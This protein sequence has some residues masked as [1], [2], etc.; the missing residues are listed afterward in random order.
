MEMEA[1]PLPL[2][3]FLKYGFPE[4]LRRPVSDGNSGAP[5]AQVSLYGRTDNACAILSTQPEVFGITA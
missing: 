2:T 4:A 5:E 3:T 1:E